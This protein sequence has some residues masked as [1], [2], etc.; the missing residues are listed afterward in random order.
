ML[1][2]AFTQIGHLV[3]ASSDFWAIIILSIILLGAIS[4]YSLLYSLGT[5]YSIIYVLIKYVFGGILN[6]LLAYMFL[7]F[8]ILCASEK[9]YRILITGSVSGAL[10]ITMIIAIE[11][12]L[13][14]VFEK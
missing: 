10:I 8:M 3:G 1:N 14:A 2:F 5:G 4:V 11:V 6:V 13:S 7:L 9:S 12:M